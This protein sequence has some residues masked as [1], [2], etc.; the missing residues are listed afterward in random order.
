MVNQWRYA[1]V[2]ALA[3]LWAACTQVDTD[4]GTAALTEADLPGGTDISVHIATPADGSTL[5]A[6]P[7]NATGTAG[8]GVGQAVPSTAILFVLDVS[9]STQS[10]VGC[11]GDQNGDGLSN[12]I[13]D[14]EILA[15]LTLNAS[16]LATGTVAEVGVVVFGAGASIADVGPA[17]GV[18]D[19]TGPATDDDLDGTPDVEQV[20]T[21]AQFG[22]VDL[23][24]PIVV[25]NS[26]TSYGS[27]VQEALDALAG[28]SQP[29]KIVVFVSDG[30]NNTGPSVAAALGPD[31]V[32]PV[33]HTFAVGAGHSCATGGALGTL[34]N[35]ANQ[36]GG[37]CTNVANVADLPDIVPSVIAAELLDIQLSLDGGAPFPPDSVV[38]AL[39]ITGP[40]AAAWEAELV[41]L[42]PGLHQLC[43]TAAGQDGGGAGLVTECVSF[44]INSAPEAICQDVTVA[45]DATCSAPASVDGGSFDP[46]GDDLTCTPVPPGPYPLGTTSVELTCTDPFG[47]SDTC[48]AT[49]EVVDLTPPEIT[50]GPALELWPPN[51]KYRA[52]TL[53]DCVAAVTDQ[54]DG[55]LDP[56]LAGRIVSIRSDEPEKAPG[57]G[58]TCDDA[59]ITGDATA[60]LRAERA[61]SG[62]GRVYTIEFVMTDT[63]GNETPGSCEVQVPHDRSGA[64]AVG[65]SCAFCVG[66]DCGTCST[67][68]PGC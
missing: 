66:A 13:L 56:D 65:G 23:F 6:G 37:T 43:A 68:S 34:Q 18:Q 67:G 20:L 30:E 51:H 29:I 60:L 1:P 47:A 2:G 57:T 22:R 48:P 25:G 8:I 7:V 17:A 31:P 24:T 38:P 46:D 53:S 40:G 42:A 41:G 27:A 35:L 19:L 15:G 44:T 14:C 62:D 4:S 55:A 33:F 9:Q 63:A 50:V 39:T 16:A 28:S 36:T 61:G 58:N 3:I 21:S 26:A 11:G 59:V 52:F 54:C 64:P 10:P 49:V 12:T 45:A 32:E 5:P